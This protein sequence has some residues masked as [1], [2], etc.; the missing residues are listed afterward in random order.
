MISQVRKGPSKPNGPI[1]LLISH[2]A[3]G[4]GAEPEPDQLRRVGLVRLGEGGADQHGDA[5]QAGVPDAGLGAGGARQAQGG[6]Q[7]HRINRQGFK[8]VRSPDNT[9]LWYY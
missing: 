4:G 3:A 5:R 7:G 9:D 6:G 8:G 2:P 1:S